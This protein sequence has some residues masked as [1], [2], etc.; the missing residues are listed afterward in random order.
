MQ[1]YLFQQNGPGQSGYLLAHW[2]KMGQN[3]VNYF[4]TGVWHENP[5]YPLLDRSSASFFCG[6]IA[7]QEKKTGHVKRIDYLLGIRI[8]VTNIG[9][10]E[11]HHQKNKDT[12]QIVNFWNAR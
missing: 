10:V 6:Q 8:T 2:Q 3:G 5:S 7:R 4:Q 11:S 12:F 9:Q 1:E